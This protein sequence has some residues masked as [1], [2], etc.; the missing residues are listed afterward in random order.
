M[1]QLHQSIMILKKNCM[2]EQ[3]VNM[4]HILDC[5]FDYMDQEKLK[6]DLRAHKITFEQ[7]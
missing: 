5:Y 4:K 3:K 7:A 1:K 6:A 2:D